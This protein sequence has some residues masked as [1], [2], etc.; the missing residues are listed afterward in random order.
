MGPTGFP[1]TTMQNEI[2]FPERFVISKL[3][4]LHSL[5]QKI[6]DW[7]MLMVTI[8]VKGPVYVVASVPRYSALGN[9][10]IEN[11][12]RIALLRKHKR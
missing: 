11:R 9:S 6:D 8:Y 4:N 3:R 5:L 7:N 2:A 10:D 1:Y 12:A